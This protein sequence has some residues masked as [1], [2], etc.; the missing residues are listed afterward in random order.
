[1]NE[2]DTK[3]FEDGRAYITEQFNETGDSAWIE[4]WICGFTDTPQRDEVK[5]KLFDHLRE[6]RFLVE[7]SK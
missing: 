3:L 2:N 7:V 1:M 4:G 6:L 5:E